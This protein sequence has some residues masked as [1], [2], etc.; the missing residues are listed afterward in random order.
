M[1][2]TIPEKWPPAVR[3][4]G[5]A[6]GI[7]AIILLALAAFGVGPF[8]PKV[9]LATFVVLLLIG[10]LRLSW[11]A[12][13]PPSRPLRWQV[14]GTVVLVIMAFLIVL[15]WREVGPF[16]HVFMLFCFVVILN[17]VQQGYTVASG[18]RPAPADPAEP[19]EGQL[20]VV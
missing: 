19:A 18:S 9:L 6:V 16:R 4:V 15:A 3:V 2:L 7:V 17:V 12:A 20:P 13:R 1:K 5:T 8:G 10:R 11:W 14:V